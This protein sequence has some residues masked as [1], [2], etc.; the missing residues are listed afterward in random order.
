MHI[1]NLIDISSYTGLHTYPPHPV[2]R[3]PSPVVVEANNLSNGSSTLED[4]E[5]S[6][7]S[8]PPSTPQPSRAP[9]V[10]PNTWHNP[11]R[12][13]SITSTISQ[14]SVTKHRHRR[15]PGIAT[16]VWN[17][18]I[19]WDNDLIEDMKVQL[20]LILQ[21]IT[22][23]PNIA[24]LATPCSQAPEYQEEPQVSR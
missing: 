22:L 12:T 21:I 13:T 3:S 10:A 17:Q 14:R 8:S 16:N 15:P 24:Y 4:E 20:L 9:S 2:A 1:V 23:T 19:K 11:P 7:L 5:L 18:T 6:V